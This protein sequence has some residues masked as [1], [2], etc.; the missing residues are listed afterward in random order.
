LS[1][2]DVVRFPTRLCADDRQRTKLMLALLMALRG[3]PFLY[4]GDELGLPHGEV[5]FERLRDPEAIAFWPS[6]I[7]RDGARTPMPWRQHANMAGF[8]DAADAWLPLDPRHRALAVDAQSAAT[9]SVL[10]FTREMIAFR[11]GS[12]ALRVGELIAMDAPE[13]VLT[14]E[15]R[16]EGERLLCLFNLGADPVRRP[17]GGRKVRFAV[18]DAELLT[19][20]A[21]LGPY[22]ALF[23][24]L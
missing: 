22:S 3:T 4:Q 6:G 17:L 2:H 16:T 15:R 11:R 19:G 7:G 5:P 1:N 8:T 21:A 24:E 14:F 23:V 9:D 12:A 10:A 18:G 13:P 20:A